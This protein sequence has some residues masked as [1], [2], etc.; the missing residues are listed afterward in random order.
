MWKS[1][2]DV[3]LM[4]KSGF[5]DHVI[6]QCV[7]VICLYKLKPMGLALDRMPNDLNTL[8]LCMISLR[9]PFMKLVALPSGKQ[10]SIHGNS[11]SSC[12]CS[13]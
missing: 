2:D 7:E 12:K 1:I 4:I 3:V 10:R 11:W 9:I 5:V 13:F 8:E 6:M